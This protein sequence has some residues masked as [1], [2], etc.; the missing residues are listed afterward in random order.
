MLS[1]ASNLSFNNTYKED[2]ACILHDN[3][4]CFRW[5]FIIVYIRTIRVSFILM[6]YGGLIEKNRR[7]R[8]KI[9]WVE[10]SCNQCISKKGKY[11]DDNELC[12]SH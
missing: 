8:N 10:E 11:K 6:N 12:S 1:K 9:K 3:D 2:D 5:F 4:A 7:I